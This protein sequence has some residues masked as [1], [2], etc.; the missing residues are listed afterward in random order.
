MLTSKVS[1]AENIK[2][3]PMRLTERIGQTTYKVNV[4]FSKT[5]KETIGDKI[6]RMIENEAANQ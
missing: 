3:E 5:S 4:H 2:N 6:I 1:K